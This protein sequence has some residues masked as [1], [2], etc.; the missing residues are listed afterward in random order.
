MLAS[1]A[2]VRRSAGPLELG[3]P[4]LGLKPALARGAA[5]LRRLAAPPRAQRAADPRAQPRHRELAVARL[6]ARVL[7]DRRD[8]WAEAALEP[9]LLL[10][11]E[12]LRRVDVEHRLDP[13]RGDVRV[14]ST[15]PGRAAGPQLDLVQWDLGQGAL[16][17]GSG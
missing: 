7:R 15:R 9:A 13:R 17:T 10:I 14:L 3:A 12:R 1:A 6:A 4:P 8:A 16:S 2:G 5:R 11:R